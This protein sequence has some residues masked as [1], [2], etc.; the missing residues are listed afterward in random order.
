MCADPSGERFF[1]LGEVLRFRDLLGSET[2]RGCA[3][4]AAA[5]LDAE[6]QSLLRNYLVDDADVAE[7]LFAPDRPLGSFAGRIDLAYML[8]LIPRL[9]ARD[10]HLIRKIRNDFAHEPWNVSF[11]TPVIA[12]RCRELRH[13]VFHEDLPARKRFMRVATGVAAF[14][15]VAMGAQPRREVAQDIDLD[16]PGVK[17]VVDAVRD[18]VF[19]YVRRPRKGGPDPEE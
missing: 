7:H 11:E 8:G 13:D 15:H 1:K 16:A 2:D 9:A 10:L 18:V 6:L 12:S 19:D 5:Y 4:T 3:L 17:E 14:I